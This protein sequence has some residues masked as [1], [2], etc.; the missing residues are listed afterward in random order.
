MDP[1]DP[2]NRTERLPDPSNNSW[3]SEDIWGHRIERQ[4]RLLLLL[5]FLSMAEAMHRSGRLLNN[6]TTSTSA[7]YRPYL[8]TQLRNI[9]F[10]D[11]LISEILD[12]NGNTEKAWETWF[13]SMAG[14]VIKDEALKDFT[15]LKSRF[16]DFATFESVVKLLSRISI[17]ELDARQW[18]HMRIYPIGPAAYYDER[19]K[20]FNSGRTQFTRTGEIAY[21]MLARSTCYKEEIKAALEK[22]FDPNSPKNQLLCTL[23]RNK[24]P[25]LSDGD[26]S[27]T[28]LPYK[29]HPSF[30][31]LAE[32][33]H[34]L[35]C[36]N[37]PAPDAFLHL[38]PLLAFHIMLYQLQTA[39][40]VMGNPK[41]AIVC[42]V[43]AP[44]S[45]QVRK[46]SIECLTDNEQLALNAV[47]RFFREKENKDVKIQKILAEDDLNEL[48]TVNDYR[49]ALKALF[50]IKE[51]PMGLTIEEVRQN[52]LKTIH[53][54]YK[55]SAGDGFRSMADEAGLRSRIKSRQHR[56]CPSDQFLRSMVVVN[57][58]KPI[59][60][61]DFLT[62]LFSRYGIVIGAVQ[63]A[64]PGTVAS[65][66]F[67]KNEFEK[68]ADRLICRLV[69]M[70]LAKRMSDSFTY[71][72]NPITKEHA[73]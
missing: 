18:N 66:L 28:Y 65:V 33:V 30:D 69:A 7:T 31:L 8:S 3:V 64:L 71:V 26:K 20:S 27:G 59:K 38:A 9:L 40:A 56:Y 62:L 21:L 50:S 60:E 36:L 25:D 47:T 63:S 51:D 14:T 15:Y 73:A 72:I 44:K 35:F 67:Q 42:E 4:P 1:F 49:N 5:E 11:P 16:E 34:A 52:A 22:A 13:A 24:K 10:K 29:S 32:D 70:G 61:T 43:L 2:N 17:K 57:V 19:D 37:M 23:M 58:T 53:K 55:E 45:T 41:P 46:A 54:N 48:S 6:A 12:D 68:N 39:A